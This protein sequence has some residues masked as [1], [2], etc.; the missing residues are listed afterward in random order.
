M[1]RNTCKYVTADSVIVYNMIE[2][3][4]N[5][6]EEHNG[7][8]ARQILAN[9]KLSDED[10]KSVLDKCNDPSNKD[11]RDLNVCKIL[12]E[13]L[14]RLTMTQRYFIFA[15]RGSEHNNGISNLNALLNCQCTLR[16]PNIMCCSMCNFKYDLN[17]YTAEHKCIQ[18]N[19]NNEKFLNGEY[20][21]EEVEVV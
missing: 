20:A 11:R 18:E 1:N 9:D 2:I 6:L 4:Y 16:D 5:G 14:L 15:Y 10:I 7:G 17:K 21:I 8:L 19:G 3:L 12:C 13:A